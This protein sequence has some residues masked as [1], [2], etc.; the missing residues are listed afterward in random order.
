MSK[1][2]KIFSD[3]TLTRIMNLEND[4]EEFKKNISEENLRLKIP[5]TTDRNSQKISFSLSDAGGLCVYVQDELKG[6]ITF[7]QEV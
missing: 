2:K 4:L 1:L 7:N 3:E 5:Y 6:E